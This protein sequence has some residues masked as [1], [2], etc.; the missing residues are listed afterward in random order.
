MRLPLFR[1][2]ASGMR[3]VLPKIA[4]TL[5]LT[6]I[7]VAQTQGSIDVQY[8]SSGGAQVPT[9]TTIEPPPEPKDNTIEITKIE[10]MD[11]A[12]N[13][14]DVT[15][16]FN[17]N[18]NPSKKVTLTLKEPGPTGLGNKKLRF[19]YKTKETINNEPNL[20]TLYR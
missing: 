14:H 13:W 20:T 7:V 5:L 6:A 12:G 16:A 18:D 10:E 11:L 15:S 17:R 19:H 9:G 1:A 4:A 3:T 8:P 2:F